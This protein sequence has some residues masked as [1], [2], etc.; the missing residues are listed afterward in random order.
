M[1]KYQICEHCGELV[2]PNWEEDSNGWEATGYCPECKKE[3]AYDCKYT[4]D[5]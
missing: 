3:M 4:G 1:D 5:F 2:I